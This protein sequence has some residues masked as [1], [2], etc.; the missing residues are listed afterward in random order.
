MKVSI[1]LIVLSFC[2]FGAFRNDTSTVIKPVV[3]QVTTYDT[4]K[5]VKTL[6][7]TTVTVKTDTIKGSLKK[8]TVK[9]VK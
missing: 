6:K 3:T 2:A 5:I 1:A 9:K 4:F 7:D 8:D